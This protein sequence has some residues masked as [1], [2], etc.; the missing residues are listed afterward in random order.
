ML[1]DE[2]KKLLGTEIKDNA[3][4]PI[5]LST[6]LL[7]HEKSKREKWL[8]EAQ[9]GKQSPEEKETIDDFEHKLNVR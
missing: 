4:L 7:L 3:Y 8:E 5:I 6:I 1:T 2:D 9:E